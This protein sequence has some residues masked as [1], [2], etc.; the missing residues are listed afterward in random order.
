MAQ[1]TTRQTVR[2]RDREISVN[3]LP[4]MSARSSVS[5]KL[6]FKARMTARMFGMTMVIPKTMTINR[7]MKSKEGIRILFIHLRLR[8]SSEKTYRPFVVFRFLSSV[9]SS[10]SA[11]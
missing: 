11:C 9:K 10:T 2:D 3:M 8:T 4:S 1:K 6:M 5:L 7:T